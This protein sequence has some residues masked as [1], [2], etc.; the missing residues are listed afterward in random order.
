MTWNTGPRMKE[1]KF[2]IPSAGSRGIPHIAMGA[3]C[4]A[5]S[6]TWDS[7]HESRTRRGRASY[8][9]EA[10]SAS[11]GIISLCESRLVLH[12]RLDGFGGHLRYCFEKVCLILCTYFSDDLLQWRINLKFA[13][14][15]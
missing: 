7:R 1:E 13:A 2:K 12:S 9:D 8:T 6:V 15:Q 11:D 14:P 10:L 5:L 3:M 4:G